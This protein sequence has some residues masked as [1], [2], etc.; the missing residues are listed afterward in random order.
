MNT[1]YARPKIEEMARSIVRSINLT[2]MSPYI[3]WRTSCVLAFRPLDLS[4]L[5]QT[6]V[7]LIDVVLLQPCL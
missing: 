3:G 1:F 7:A 2:V 4:T 6:T 5:S